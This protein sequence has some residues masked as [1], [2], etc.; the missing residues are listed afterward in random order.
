VLARAGTLATSFARD[1]E[2][3]RPGHVFVAP[4]DH[5]LLVSG[6]RLRVTHGPT[7]HG[8]RPAVD[9]LFRTASREHGPR[10]VGVILSGSLDDGT[11]GLALVK[12]H[13]GVAVVQRVEDALMPGMPA[14][15]IQ[16]VAVDHV[17]PAREIGGLLS[18]LAR[19]QVTID[20]GGRSSQPDVAQQGTAELRSGRRRRR[21]TTPLTCPDCGG[22]LR[23]TRLLGQTRLRCHVGHG[24]TP[25][26][27]AAAQD[28]GL[29]VA[30]WTAIR[31]LEE[32][33]LLRRRLADRTRACGLVAMAESYERLAGESEERASMIRKLLTEPTVWDQTGNVTAES[34]QSGGGWRE[35]RSR[36]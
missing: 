15:A 4:P 22:S 1:G 14:S 11:L 13:G 21:R 20:P 12:R 17:L 6:E 16:N 25:L 33:A 23:E 27:L 30:L 36:R 8:L 26:T 24:F 9:P 34:G 10:V 3:I 2:D 18:R 31:S 28:K 5:H 29:D 19:E 32:S 35:A 7:E